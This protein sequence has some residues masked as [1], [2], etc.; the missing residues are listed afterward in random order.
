LKKTKK[1]VKNAIS[2]TWE[3][4]K[5]IVM[6]LSIL[7]IVNWLYSAIVI[8]IAIYNAGTFSYLDTLIT[9]TNET[10]RIV[11]GANVIKSCIENVFKYNDIGGKAKQNEDTSIEISEKED[12]GLG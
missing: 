5:K 7:Y 3:F 10:F 8:A 11:V 2:W 1:G 9:E 6:L 4:T 12:E